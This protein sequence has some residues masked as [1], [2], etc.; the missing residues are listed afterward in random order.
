MR[1]TRYC[2]RARRASPWRSRR[3]KWIIDWIITDIW[4][5]IIS[6]DRLIRVIRAICIW[7]TYIKCCIIGRVS[8]SN[9]CIVIDSVNCYVA[10]REIHFIYLIHTSFRLLEGCRCRDKRNTGRKSIITRWFAYIAA[11]LTMFSAGFRAFINCF[12]TPCW[13]TTV[14]LGLTRFTLRYHSA[15]TLII[16][17]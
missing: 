1:R 11:F 13:R 12:C 7:R 14:S 15:R 6:I 8:Y 10:V 3:S 4:W 2:R 9:G 16:L 17:Y 5:I